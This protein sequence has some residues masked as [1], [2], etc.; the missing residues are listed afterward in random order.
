MSSSQAMIQSRGI[1]EAKT[2]IR[3]DIIY[4]EDQKRPANHENKLQSLAS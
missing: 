2:I 4:R 1:N 3:M